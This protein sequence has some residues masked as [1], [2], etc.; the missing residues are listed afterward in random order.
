MLPNELKLILR[1]C[2]GENEI[3]RSCFFVRR[4]KKEIRKSDKYSVNIIRYNPL[5]YA[6]TPV[7]SQDEYHSL[8]TINL[9][10]LFPGV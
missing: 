6:V 8:V 9:I 1:N 2:S 4:W 10:Q 5:Y 3:A 7:A